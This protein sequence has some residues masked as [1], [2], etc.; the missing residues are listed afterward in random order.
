MKRILSVMLLLMVLSGCSTQTESKPVVK[1][2]TY[3]E[4]VADGVVYDEKWTIEGMDDDVLYKTTTVYTY[5]FD[6]LDVWSETIE[7]LKV[8]Y[9]EEIEKLKKPLGSKYITFEYE[10]DGNALTATETTD[11]KSASDNGMNVEGHLDGG[12]MTSQE[13]YSVEMLCEELEN[14]G[15]TLVE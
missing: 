8:S 13:Y 14:S 2:Y 12:L 1:E 11:Y 3:S 4:E 6:D 10:M 9:D 15:Y 5:T 7:E